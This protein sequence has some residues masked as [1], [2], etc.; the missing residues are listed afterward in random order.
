MKQ[1]YIARIDLM[2]APQE[3]T[4]DQLPRT[5]ATDNQSFDFN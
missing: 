1:P 2:M 3:L 4:S 5:S